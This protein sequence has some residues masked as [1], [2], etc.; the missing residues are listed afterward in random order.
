LP[1]LDPPVACHSES[2]LHLSLPPLNL[3]PP[4]RAV[5]VSAALLEEQL[6]QE[7][8]SNQPS[9]S[10]QQAAATDVLV[11]HGDTVVSRQLSTSEWCSSVMRCPGSLLPNLGRAVARS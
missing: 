10:T 5:A 4:P 6:L 7:A 9:S 3:P 1:L 8:A 2:A 11:T